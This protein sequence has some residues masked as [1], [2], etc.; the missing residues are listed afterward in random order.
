M[1]RLNSSLEAGAAN[2]HVVDRSLMKNLLLSFVVEKE[3]KKTEILNVLVKILGYG[4]RERSQ[5]PFD[6]K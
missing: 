2:E 4:E 5:V 1:S 3:P 6:N